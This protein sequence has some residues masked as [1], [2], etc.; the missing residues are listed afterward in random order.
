[1]QVTSKV[2]R[3]TAIRHVLVASFAL[4]QGPSVAMAED[5]RCLEFQAAALSNDVKGVADFINSHGDVNCVDPATG[6]TAL[7]QA[8]RNG[9]VEA[10]KLVLLAGADIGAR[11]SS[12]ETALTIATIT[13]N[14][15]ERGGPSFAPLRA[16]I[17]EGIAALRQAGA[18]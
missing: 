9:S 3:R 2:A 12:G 10:L 6:E 8:A 17:A 13:F 1:M 15:L 16:R 5:S 18:H 11:T 4:M 14:A 7:M